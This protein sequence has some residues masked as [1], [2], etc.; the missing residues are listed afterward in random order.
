MPEQ[1]ERERRLDVIAKAIESLVGDDMPLIV[2]YY[3]AA[4][5]LAVVE[6]WEREERTK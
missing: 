3:A 6:R 5:A 4:D 1:T 2:G